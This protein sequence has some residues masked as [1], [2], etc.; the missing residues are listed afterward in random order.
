MLDQPEIVALRLIARLHN[1]DIRQLCRDCHDL[2]DALQ[3]LGRHPMD[4]PERAAEQIERCKQLGVAVLAWHDPQYPTRLLDIASPPAVLFVRGSLPEP[5]R[6]MLA[7]VGTRSCTIH[8]GK[9]VTEVLVE[10]WTQRGAVIISGL[11]HGIDTVAHETTVRMRGSTVAVIAS[12]IDRITPIVAQRMADRIVEG[13]GCI[14][15]E[16]PCGVAALPPAFPARNRIISGMSDA[17][18]VVESKRRGGALIT[19]DF[20]RQQQRPLYAVP[21]PITSSRSEGCNAL[22]ADASAR[23]LTCADDLRELPKWSAQRP[24]FESIDGLDTGTPR[25]LDEIAMHWNCSASETMRRLLDLELEGRITRL[26]G[27]TFLARAT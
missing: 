7:I 21:G 26:P 15:S 2:D 27:N 5:A 3:R 19:A 23:M 10:S 6:P 24:A 22:I 11:A 9:P 20:A 17:V 16:H 18:V 1:D 4:L 25:H 14:V 13:G 8:Y 12:G